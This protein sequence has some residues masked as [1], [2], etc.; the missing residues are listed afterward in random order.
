M[1][2][3]AGT[4]SGGTPAIDMRGPRNIELVAAVGGLARLEP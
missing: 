1:G 3:E 2:V 4:D